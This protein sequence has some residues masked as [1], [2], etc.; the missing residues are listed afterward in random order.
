MERK[1]IQSSALAEVGYDAE[2][3]VLEVLFPSRAL[4]RY[5]SVPKTTY[6]ALLSAPSAGQYFAGQI[7]ANFRAERV[8]IEECQ[9]LNGGSVLCEKTA[10]PCWCHN[11]VKSSEEK[12]NAEVP[13]A[14]KSE[15]KR[16]AIQKNKKAS[17]AFS[18]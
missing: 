17:K 11:I 13:P 1:V 18:V 5:Y 16:K 8:H 12:K 10:C 14:S 3:Q 9:A 15:E 4:W 6:E 7:R 2:T